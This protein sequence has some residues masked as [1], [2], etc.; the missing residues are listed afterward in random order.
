[1][2]MATSEKNESLQQVRPYRGAG[3]TQGHPADTRHSML[4][5][6]THA[7]KSL[8]RSETI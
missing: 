5:S 3:K 7:G 8:N 6:S 4:A 2:A 1:V